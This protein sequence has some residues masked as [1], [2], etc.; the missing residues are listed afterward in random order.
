MAL[1][2]NLKGL[3]IVLILFSMLLMKFYI[4]YL[5]SYEFALR[6]D[7]DIVKLFHLYDNWLSRLIV[8]ST[9]LIFVL[10]YYMFSLFKIERSFNLP[11]LY[12]TAIISTTFIINT[13]F[14]SD[15]IEFSKE[16]I[17][18]YKLFV[19]LINRHHI[20]INSSLT[21][22]VLTICIIISI[23]FEVDSRTEK[24]QYYIDYH[25]TSNGWAK[26]S[27]NTK[28]FSFDIYPTKKSY[29]TIRA[30]LNYEISKKIIDIRTDEYF[31]KRNGDEDFFN[32]FFDEEIYINELKLIL[33]SHKNEKILKYLKEYKEFYPFSLKDIKG[34][35][36]LDYLKMDY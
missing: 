34:I 12:L 8:F 24:N 1:K 20:L 3:I 18:E 30:I 21:F 29:M 4:D 25:L 16:F 32:R 11:L 33:M 35:K 22:I 28:E 17:N 5:Y 15:L 6:G 26:G 13:T 7:I 31:E 14:D 2:E 9:I 23:H 19:P 10:I 27:I 36:Q